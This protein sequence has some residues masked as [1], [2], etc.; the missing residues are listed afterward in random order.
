MAGL[1]IQR[2]HGIEPLARLA[3]HARPTRPVA[4]SC[5]ARPKNMAGYR[6]IGGPTYSVP[7][8]KRDGCGVRG[9]DQLSGNGIADESWWPSRRGPR[10]ARAAGRKRPERGEVAK[11]ADVELA[12]A[13]SDVAK[14]QVADLRVI[15]SGP[16]SE[17][18][19][20][21]LPL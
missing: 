1:K 14:T 18:R 3:P 19:R 6:R 12:S 8:A 16:V 4:K 10:L 13:R 17:P 2:F 11:I 9:P 20:T 21:F 5:V 7:C 15:L